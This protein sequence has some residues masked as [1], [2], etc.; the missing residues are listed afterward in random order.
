MKEEKKTKT[1]LRDVMN[2][3][4]RVQSFSP[5][6]AMARC[7]AYI[8][9]RQVMDKLDEVVGPN[10]W[11]DNY[12]KVNGSLFGGIGIFYINK[13]KD[14]LEVGEGSWIWKWDTGSESN[15]EKE[16]GQASDAFKRAAV[17]WGIGRFLYEKE[18]VMVKSSKAKANNNDFPYVIDNNGKR[19]WDLTKHINNG[20]SIDFE[21]KSA[22]AVEINSPQTPS[23]DFHEI[24]QAKIKKII[25]LAESIG[26]GYLQT[27]MQHLADTNDITALDELSDTQAD[28]IISDLN[29]TKK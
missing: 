10:N 4:W 8:D 13:D 11:Q 7:V 23:S 17:K 19:V 20:G 16:K 26:E 28:K 2:C 27:L 29:N 5:T 18:T 22:P 6:S 21:Q 12:K 15:I 3:K 9:A 1:E 14:G 24:P 25:A